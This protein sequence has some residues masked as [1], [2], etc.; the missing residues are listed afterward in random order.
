MPVSERKRAA[1][2]AGQSLAAARGT[3]GGGLYRAGRRDERRRGHG[4][5]LRDPV[6]D[7]GRPRMTRSSTSY[8]E[9]LERLGQRCRGLR[10]DAGT[11][12]PSA[13]CLDF[14]MIT[15]VTGLSLSPGNEQYSYWGAKTVDV[16][17]LAQPDGRLSPRPIEANDPA[18]A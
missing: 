3:G 18:D 10:V 16:N 1:N 15:S 5:L 2:R 17:R 8:S 9:T 12:P 11:V 14:D 6:A 4:F 7:A 13:R